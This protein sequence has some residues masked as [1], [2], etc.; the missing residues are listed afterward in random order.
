M[1]DKKRKEDVVRRPLAAKSSDGTIKP[2]YCDDHS[3]N[4]ATFRCLKC[5]HLFCEEC[6]GGVDEGK[7]YCVGCKGFYVQ[8]E[9]KA[10]AKKKKAA[11]ATSK[12][13]EIAL[14]GIMVALILLLGGYVLI[15]STPPVPEQLPEMEGLTVAEIQEDA[16]I[17]AEANHEIAE[18]DREIE[19]LL[20]EGPAEAGG[21]E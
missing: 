17:S 12:S 6:V 19:A 20:V 7:T 16:R 14:A 18:L 11:A 2:L 1:S 10:K 9:Q 21:V 8:E 3:K 5:G 4:K 13:V 15:N